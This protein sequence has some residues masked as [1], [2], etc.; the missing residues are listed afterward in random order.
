MANFLP[1]P[2]VYVADCSEEVPGQTAEKHFS[3]DIL[4]HASRFPEMERRNFLWSRLIIK[5]VP[6]QLFPEEELGYSIFE[7]YSNSPRIG[8]FHYRFVSVSSYASSVAVALSTM[9][10]NVCLT[11]FNW[12]PEKVKAEKTRLPPMFLNWIER[13]NNPPL[14]FYQLYCAQ[15]CLRK[16][17]DPTIKILIGDDDTLK[18]AGAY[19]SLREALML[20]TTPEWLC[21]IQGPA[22][23]TL[24]TEVRTPKK[25]LGL[26]EGDY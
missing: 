23:D 20:W 17:H 1:P 10:I 3:P 9:P 21:S 8:D 22:L 26:L 5:T 15:S 7:D 12:S 14:A 13:Q 25:T 4:E 16:R 2:I 19:A 6:L 11:K 24:M 18:V